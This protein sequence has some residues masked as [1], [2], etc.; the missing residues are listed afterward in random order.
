M[1]NTSEVIQHKQSKYPALVSPDQLA[2]VT[3][4]SAFTIR[5]LCRD[6]KLHAIKI[7]SSWRINRDATFSEYGINE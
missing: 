2:E 1:T 7:G 4:I 3:G 6:G 5:K